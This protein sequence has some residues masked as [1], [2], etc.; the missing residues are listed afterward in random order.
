M[1]IPLAVPLAI[2]AAS[3]LAGVLGNRKKQKGPDMAAINAEIARGSQEQKNIIASR[4]PQTQQLSTQFGQDM[5]AKTAEYGAN[6]ANIGN[7]YF[8]EAGKM[9]DSTGTQL[10]DVLRRR[11]LETLPQEQQALGEA[12]AA[13]GGG[14]TGAQLQA[15]TNL[16][17]QASKDVGEGIT[18]ITLQQGQQR[19]QALKD[20]FGMDTETADKVLGLEAGTLDALFQSNRQDLID[21]ANSY[22]EEAVRRQDSRLTALQNQQ[23]NDLANQLAKRESNNALISGG[24]GG[25]TNILGQMAAKK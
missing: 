1:P 14:G 17:T 13:G 15:A 5:A 8:Q 20:K 12:I 22:L 2:S 21:E 9:Q 7:Q 24:V 23:R 19:A 25:L 3:T 10:T 6:R 11:R 4:R 16:A 18:N